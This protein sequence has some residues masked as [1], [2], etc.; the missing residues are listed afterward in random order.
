[1]SKQ[2]GKWTLAL[3]R[4]SRPASMA[5]FYNSQCVIERE[6]PPMAA[7]GSTAWASVLRD[8]LYDNGVAPAELSLLVVGLGPG[9]F[10]GARSAIAFLH[11]L[12]IP[13]GIP[14]AGVGSA[15]A[16]AFAAARELD[17]GKAVAVAGDARRSRWWR[18]V[19]TTVESAESPSGRALRVMKDGGISVPSHAA[20]DF[21]L[22][23]TNLDALRAG[24]P[25]DAKWLEIETLVAP[26]LAGSLTLP[27][28]RDLGELALSEP[29]AALAAPLPIY[30][31]PAVLPPR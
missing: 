15:A 9:S 8:L 6:F 28:A 4:S 16:A 11:G 17:A 14:V 24:V 20:A 19:F 25:A 3:E 12:A 13:D 22:V 21:D 31:H 27:T 30:L 5:L 10:S 7:H 26:D 29:S 18:A 1:M 23:E 2:Q